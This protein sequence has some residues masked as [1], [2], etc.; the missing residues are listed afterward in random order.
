M[1]DA[2]IINDI[3]SNSPKFE[4]KEQIKLDNKYIEVITNDKYYFNNNNRKLNNKNTDDLLNME[5]IFSEEENNN[6]ITRKEMASVIKK[7]DKKLKNFSSKKITDIQFYC[8]SA[9][10]QKKKSVVNITQASVVRGYTNS[11]S[12]VTM[13]CINPN[14]VCVT[15]N[16][17]VNACTGHFGLVTLNKKFPHPIFKQALRLVLECV[18]HYCGHTF[19]K[20]DHVKKLGLNKYTAI[21]RLTMLSKITPKMYGLHTCEKKNV[22]YIKTYINDYILAY[23]KKDQD[24]KEHKIERTMEDVEKILSVLDNEDL[25]VLGLNR[26]NHPVNWIMKNLLI[27]PPCTRPTIY[28]DGT[29]KENFMTDIYL[30]IISYNN[31]IRNNI[32]SNDKTNEIK[33]YEYITKLID[34]GT[35]SKNTNE[36][37]E[38]IFKF[39]SGKTGL[40]R[41]YILGKRVNYCTRT[42]AGPASEANFGEIL[43]PR[44]VAQTLTI[45][46]KVTIYNYNRL[47]EDMIN[48]NAHSI[49]FANSESD[50]VMFISDKMRETHKLKIGDT[51]IRYMIDGDYLMVGRQPTLHAES[52]M[53]FKTKIHDKKTIGLHS[54]I[55]AAFNADFDG[56]ELNGHLLQ[57]TGAQCEAATIANCKN[58]IMNVQSNKAM[59][60][61]AYN[62]ILATFLMT[63]EWVYDDINDME[64]HEWNYPDKITKKQWAEIINS[65]FGEITIPNTRYKEALNVLEDSS[66]KR[67]LRKRC[68]KNNV[69]PRSSKSLFSVIFPEDFFFTLNKFSEKKIIVNGKEKIIKIDE[70]IVIKDGILISGTLKKGNVAN[71]EGSFVQILTNIYSM[72]K[73]WDF[74][75]DGQKICDWFIMWH[76]FTLGYK[77]IDNN[78]S[79]IIK[80]INEKTNET[81]NKFYL[82]GDKPKDPILEF[83]WNRSASTLLTNTEQIGKKIGESILKQNNELKILGSDG[84]GAKGN[85]ANT[86]QLLGSL[87]EQFLSDGLPKPSMKNNRTSVFYTEND[88]SISAIG[89]VRNNFESGLTLPE[90]VSHLSASRQ[91]IIDTA[92]GTGDIGYIARKFRLTLQNI[93]FDDTK[94]ISNEKGNIF[95][96]SGLGDFQSPSLQVTTQ[97]KVNGKK[98]TFCNVNNI[99]NMV[100]SKYENSL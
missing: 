31:K 52:F 8:M 84:S 58:H 97:N 48:G 67:T 63:Q 60:G 1:G 99:A 85:S 12:D 36:K 66:R 78:K 40:F 43:L 3:L 24:G 14:E 61:L 5:V 82:L 26:K 17:N 13:G 69:N 80:L 16:G 75:N 68:E 41:K 21:K 33:L 65:D 45:P 44:Q 10:D 37:N 93:T 46:E 98:V 29:A 81:Q 42:V 90:M 79:D 9:E 91:G 28:V 34:S 50:Q 7:N 59:M 56:D 35:E 62:A 83:F 18:C 53:T 49:I 20:N 89:Y 77:T 92:L 2:S 27:C 74:I 38:S 51:I 22:D 64:F 39:L 94:C 54:S 72:E 100:N 96:F 86:A 87:G 76:N 6:V 23:N 30:Y 73:S 57:T 11:L 70:S 95:S 15:C 25:D 88:V 55:N 47:S 19:L 32:N 4:P 71:T